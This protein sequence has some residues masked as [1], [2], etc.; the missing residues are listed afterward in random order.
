MTHGS[1]EHVGVLTTTDVA[2]ERLA[3][4]FLGYAS[5]HCMA[6]ILVKPLFI[7]VFCETAKGTEPELSLFKESS[8][9]L[10]ADIA[11]DYG[12]TDVPITNDQW[13]RDH[14][15]HLFCRGDQVG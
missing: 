14:F 2:S 5:Q 1:A 4:P 7:S 13:S 11:K 9:V 6:F 3:S 10:V 12:R 15:V 8:N